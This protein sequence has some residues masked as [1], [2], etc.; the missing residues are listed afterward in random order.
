[1]YTQV[2]DHELTH[3]VPQVLRQYFEGTGLSVFDTASIFLEV[4]N[5]CFK[6]AC[7]RH[8]SRGGGWSTA[9]WVMKDPMAQA[10]R[11][12]AVV[13]SPTVRDAMFAAAEYKCSECGEPKR[14]HWCAAADLKQQTKGILEQLGDIE[15]ECDLPALLLNQQ[16]RLIA[17][18][19]PALPV[20]DDQP[21]ETGVPGPSELCPEGLACQKGI[22]C[23]YS[24]HSLI[25]DTPLQQVRLRFPLMANQAGPAAPPPAATAG[26]PPRVPVAAAAVN[27]LVVAAAAAAAARQSQVQVAAR[28]AAQLLI[29]QLLQQGRSG[30]SGR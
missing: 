16:L 15:A 13:Q 21:R 24:R 28:A 2:Y 12:L 1:M 8:T 22:S 5:R 7:A 10:L 9:T 25:D 14:G 30:A 3:H 26:R 18:M 17:T 29:Q 23:E 11:H 19:P 4:L 27:D 20:V 6:E